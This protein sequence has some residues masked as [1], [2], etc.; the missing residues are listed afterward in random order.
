MGNCR[1]KTTSLAT[2]KDSN[3]PFE[4]MTQFSFIFDLKKRDSLSLCFVP[5][6]VACLLLLSSEVR[7]SRN[8]ERM[9]RRINQHNL[10]GFRNVI[11]LI[12]FVSFRFTNISFRSVSFQ[13]LIIFLTFRFVS[14]QKNIVSFRNVSGSCKFYF[15]PFRFVSEK[16][17][18]LA[19]RS[20]SFR[21]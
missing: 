10:S 2:Q 7:K 14:F 17:A 18:F 21:F 20:V 16:Y 9:Q 11:I 13:D 12:R 15:V 5:S 3:E 8:A 1:G 19:L 4:T 6:Q